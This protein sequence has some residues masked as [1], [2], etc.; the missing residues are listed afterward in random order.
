MRPLHDILL[1]ICIYIFIILYNY[2]IML[3]YLFELMSFCVYSA[4]VG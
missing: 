4:G 3:L 1:Y 2:L